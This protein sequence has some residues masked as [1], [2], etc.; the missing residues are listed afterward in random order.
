MLGKDTFEAKDSGLILEGKHF[1]LQSNPNLTLL[2]IIIERNLLLKLNLITVMAMKSVLV[3][4][5]IS[6]LMVS[7]GTMFLAI[8]ENQPFVNSN[9]LF[10]PVFSRIK[11]M[12]ILLN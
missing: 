7:N 2:L 10:H 12:L 11:F 5:T 4:S 1:G 3:S 6:M 8:I 9:N